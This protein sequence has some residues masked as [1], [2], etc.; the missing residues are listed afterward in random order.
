MRNWTV[1]RNDVFRNNEACA[2][3]DEAPPVSGVG[4]ALAGTKNASVVENSAVNNRPSGP[5]AFRGGISLF[6]AGPGYVPRDNTV[7]GN[8][9][10]GNRPDLFYDGTGG[11]RL[12]QQRLR[13]L[14][15]AGPLL[16]RALDASMTASAMGARLASRDRC[17]AGGRGRAARD[18]RGPRGR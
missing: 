10:F 18:R 16:T 17:R 1:R 2:A 15:A 13:H 14:P 4:I 3:S 12:G 11:K 8:A 7:R 6:K 9:A 5:S